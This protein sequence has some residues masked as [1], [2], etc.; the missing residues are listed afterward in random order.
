MNKK[1]PYSRLMHWYRWSEYYIPGFNTAART[2]IRAKLMKDRITVDRHCKNNKLAYEKWLA[3]TEFVF[4]VASP[5]SGTVFMTDLLAK[6]LEGKANVVHEG[7]IIDY[8]AF[9]MA[10]QSL[11]AAYDYFN[12]FKLKDIF[13]RF[14]ASNMPM[15]IE[16]SPFLRL[17]GKIIQESI[18]DAKILHIVRNGKESVRSMMSRNMLSDKDPMNKWVFPPNEDPYKSKWEEMD[19]FE[20]ICWQWQYA[21]KNMSKNV[22]HRL[23]FEKLRTDYSYFKEGIVDF[24]GIQISEEDWKNHVNNPKNPS[25]IHR[26]PKWEEWDSSRLDSFYDICGEEMKLYNYD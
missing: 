18:P 10:I 23:F 21:N 8:Y 25:V 5:R 16:I 4:G 14:G 26:F 19:L 22:S 6:H 1:R 20:R 15:Y 3:E 2:A 9:G 24:L 17:H 7:S 11:D 13:Y 12:D